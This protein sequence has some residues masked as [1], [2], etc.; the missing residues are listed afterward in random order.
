MKTFPGIFFLVLVLISLKF[1]NGEQIKIYQNSSVIEFP[2][3][4]E[5]EINLRL[6]RNQTSEFFLGHSFLSI[7][8]N[9]TN[10][11]D[12]S[13]NK[14]SPS[15][16]A[17]RM[18]GKLNEAPHPEI[19]SYD[20]K[21]DTGKVSNG[22]TLYGFEYSP[23]QVD[24]NDTTLYIKLIGVE[25]KSNF[26]L[27]V[28][29]DFVDEYKVICPSNTAEVKPTLTLHSS[30]VANKLG[31]IKVFGKINETEI[32][33]KMYLLSDDS[34]GNVRWS[35]I[36][37]SAGNKP[38]PRYG[39]FMTEF[40]DFLILFGGRDAKENDLNDL[41][42]M[43]LSTSNHYTWTKID[44]PANSTH[45]PKG[46]FLPAGCV[47]KNYG[48][49][50]IYG[51]KSNFDDVNLYYLDLKI[52][53]EI[54]KYKQQ[55]NKK[56]EED[57]LTWTNTDQLGKSFKDKDKSSIRDK[58]AQDKKQIE[59]EIQNKQNHLWKFEEKPEL[60][61]RYG[62]TITQIKDEEVLFFGGFDRS[63]YPSSRMEILNLE[64]HQV[65]IVEATV[66]S[67]FPYARGFHSVLK[68]GSILI[69][70]GGKIG[71]GENL[72][73]L[74]KYV[75]GTGKWIRVKELESFTS[76]EFYLYK[77]MYSFTKLT[78]AERPVIFGGENRNNEL[79][80]DLIVLDFDICLSDT[81][82][83]SE[84]QCLPCAEGFELNRQNKCVKCP[85]GTYHEL[86]K[87]KD[88][89]YNF[90]A[91]S[92]CMKCPSRTY[93]EFE[94]AVGISSCKIC[95][96]GY[97]NKEAGQVKCNTCPQGELCLP[98]TDY[99]I[100]E[101][102]LNSKNEEGENYKMDLME[103]IDNNY[104]VDY[105]N[106]DFI[107]KNVK[108]RSISRAAAFISV[109]GITGSMIL[110]LLIMY[111]VKK[112]ET[113][114]FLIHTDFL[115]LTGGTA[116]KCSGG[117]ITMFYTILI[118][119]LS[120]SF[121]VRY[122]YFNEVI[123]VIPIGHSDSAQETIKSSFILNVDI[124]GREFQC[125]NKN[126]ELNTEEGLYG[127]G[128]D[129]KLSI[130]DVSNTSKSKVLSIFH[131]EKLYCKENPNRGSCEIAFKCEDCK[132][133]NNNEIFEIELVNPDAFVQVFHWGFESFWSEDFEVEKGYSKLEG[134]FKPD[135]NIKSNYVFKGGDPNQVQIYLTPI[136][137]SSKVD[138][139]NLAGFRASTRP[140]I[141]G[142]VRNEF[143]FYR[144]Q[145]GVKLQ[146]QF[147]YSTNS[148]QINAKKQ[149]EFL[150]FFGFIMGMIA[151]FS[152]LSRISKYLC[153][154]CNIFNVSEQNYAEM[155]DEVVE[156][157]VGRK[158]PKEEKFETKV[159]MKL[160]PGFQ[161]TQNNSNSVNSVKPLNQ[162]K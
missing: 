7:I 69:L 35:L 99:P 149:I 4:L 54:Y 67:E 22:Y 127:C 30:V 73:D 119:S 139:T 85:Q 5:Y 55:L 129:V 121:I 28:N 70:Y 117:F 161:N 3:I 43:D 37:I 45:A 89:N 154:R 97:Y 76:T 84:Q 123:E 32:D 71:T 141:L 113:T 9:V 160:N 38:T 29:L 27:T 83:L 41:W 151:G 64:T 16:Q 98:G 72:N 86:N 112:P 36:P 107:D 50:I 2:N 47:I 134:I 1:N 56:E 44:F 120:V 46:K 12:F 53:F 51:G 79:T 94:G 34:Q 152:F 25:S 59:F 142:S 114:K 52:L 91:D 80:N 101:P 158:D 75:I 39:A 24:L 157:E 111:K 49:I 90:Y 104:L 162:E 145:N 20:K 150:D 155:I 128:K 31:T 116:Q 18:Y 81:K 60:V 21:D 77:S 143:D 153:E 15:P 109:A 10:S 13:S 78:N 57:F 144:N 17:L 115:V 140:Y 130:F 124:I 108:I 33:D 61:P 42:V 100:K 132:S 26:T 118:I 159:E 58:Q 146:F 137:Y 19:L 135:H 48:K 93:N 14:K 110:I 63:D 92:K 122:L 138:G 105:N 6:L 68:L 133:L 125:V 148:S 40:E 102:T 88:K 96:F 87:D 156:E 11:G 82:I 66:P 126:D 23:C 136:F 74:W 131:K 65:Q 62:L 106:P 147:I 8:A 95:E 103:A